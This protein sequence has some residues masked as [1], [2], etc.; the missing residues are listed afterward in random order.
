M[1]A[2]EQE[3]GFGGEDRIIR[4]G[5]CCMCDAWKWHASS[6]SISS[7]DSDAVLAAGGKITAVP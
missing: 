5:G 2:T 1:V 7:A 6:S 3:E 4:Q